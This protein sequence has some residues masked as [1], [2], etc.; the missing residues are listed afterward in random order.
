MSNLEKASSAEKIIVVT[1]VLINEF[2]STNNRDSIA[3]GIAK[4]LQDLREMLQ[5]PQI[6]A[7]TL[8][9]T[10]TDYPFFGLKIKTWA[11]VEVNNE[12]STTHD[13]LSV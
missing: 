4:F 5:Y 10:I 11:K 8:K 13:K 9:F 1:S 7:K 2:N 6:D 3:S 12:G